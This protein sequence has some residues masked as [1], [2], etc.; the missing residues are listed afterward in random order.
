VGEEAGLPGGYVEIGPVRDY[1]TEYAQPSPRPLDRH[2]SLPMKRVTEEKA[3]WLAASDPAT[4]YVELDG[5]HN[6]RPHLAFAVHYLLRQQESNMLA[7]GRGSFRLDLEGRDFARP[8]A[9]QDDKATVPVALPA[10]LLIRRDATHPLRGRPGKPG[11]LIV[12]ASTNGF[13]SPALFGPDFV[14]ELLDGDPP[15]PLESAW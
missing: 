3:T 1:M 11:W 9:M 6:F 7:T 14:A 5:I 10:F 8:G 15:P 13:T 12:R 2:V 4:V